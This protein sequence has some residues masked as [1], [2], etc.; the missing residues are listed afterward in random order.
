M[1]EKLN[2]RIDEIKDEIIGS[3]Q[4]IIQIKSVE[5]EAE[6]GMPFGQG[7]NE[8]LETTLHIADIMG[9]DTKNL[10]GYAGHVELGEGDEI[11][12]ILCHL[13]VVPEGSNWTYAPYGAEI[14]DGKL[15]GRGSI[16]DK[17]PAIAALYALKAVRDCE[18]PLSKKVRLIFGTD[19][20]S[21]WQGLE[22]Y[23][24]KEKTPDIAFSPD[25]DFPVIHGEKGILTF[26]IKKKLK[27]STLDKIKSIKIEGGNAPNMVPD[28][29]RAVIET[30]YQ[31]FMKEKMNTYVEDTESVNLEAEI[32]EDN[33][34]IESYGVS[35][36]G[37]LPEQGKNAISQL[38][39]FLD[40]FE[41]LE[42]NISDIIDF[43]NECIAMEY[44]GES[45]GCQM[46]D[47]V[48]GPLTFNVGMINI[49]EKMAE[50][51]VNIRYPVTVEYETVVEKIKNTLDDYGFEYEEL[52]HMGPLYVEKDDPLVKKLMKV[53]QEYTGD[54][55]EPVTI[56]G[57]TYARAI[58]KAVA[59]GPAFPGR[60]ELAH[61]KDEF[62]SIDDL[63]L[64]TKIYAAAIVEL[65]GE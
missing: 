56:G 33:I 10:D 23:L 40:T 14:V 50:I 16:D 60:A 8:C 9:F 64:I 48:S 1:Y 18:I 12:G 19:E 21:G 55:S 45:M 53:Y 65:A 35:S 58:D 61:Q 4:K 52:S 3:A 36:H 43:Y 34:I 59:F 42:G 25:A 6:E 57:G 31:D 63:I 37:S 28:Y 7:I 44:Y 13:D 24:K 54:Q 22:Y 41:I 26:N 30:D 2:N 5:S 29:C 51:T 62:L 47:D 38:M 15:Y 49:D 46:E 11:L 32:N 27:N 39:I 20:E 17:G